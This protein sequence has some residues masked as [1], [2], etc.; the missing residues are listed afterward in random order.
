L[1]NPRKSSSGVYG[2]IRTIARASHTGQAHYELG[3]V[4]MYS[5]HFD[6]A[7]S[8][9]LVSSLMRPRQARIFGGRQM[10]RS[11][12]RAFG[13]I[14]AASTKA[15][16]SRL[17]RRRL[18]SGQNSGGPGSG[19]FDAGEAQISLS[20]LSGLPDGD[21][22]GLR[23]RAKNAWM[24]CSRCATCRIRRRARDS[25]AFACAV[26]DGRLTADWSRS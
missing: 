4:E 1:I 16:K 23:G 18:K 26:V 20:M 7:P 15:W 3:F 12:W 6:E 5:G 14:R 8:R 19:D 9:T 17:R 25:P 13:F 21:Q 22:R 2:C 24:M 11:P 10:A